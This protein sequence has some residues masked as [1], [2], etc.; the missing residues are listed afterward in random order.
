ML[1][2]KTLL[3]TT[4]MGT[5]LFA[6]CSKDN[7]DVTPIQNTDGRSAVSMRW[8]TDVPAGPSVVNWHAGYMNADEIQFDA[9]LMGKNN[10]NG[11]GNGNGN[12]GGTHVHYKSKVDQRIDLFNPVPFG[13]LMIPY[14]RYDN[15]MLKVRREPSPASHA[16]YLEGDYME[17]GINVPVTIVVDETMDLKAKWKDPLTIANGVDYLSFL[18][19]NLAELIDGLTPGMLQQASLTNGGL[20][21][22]S[23]SNQHIYN[24]I[25]EN[26]EDMMK[27][28]FE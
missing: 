25:L 12:N 22:S 21:I 11:N 24:M 14:G 15:V 27:V 6:S 19:F 2:T 17:N 8:H 23:S 20:V 18:S 1:P 26:L 3:F 16:L 9:K 7:D 10:G 5:A 4:L 28:K 13:N